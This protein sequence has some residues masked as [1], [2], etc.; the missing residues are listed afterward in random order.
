M[1]TGGAG[2]HGEKPKTKAGNVARAIC[3]VN[4]L[5]GLSAGERD[6]LKRSIAAAAL[7]DV[8]AREDIIV[9]CRGQDREIT[10]E[11]MSLILPAEASAPGG[12]K[13]TR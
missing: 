13:A 2:F 10:A 6:T 9:F 3:L 8:R 4:S 1:R 11:I 7:G 12:A 5:G